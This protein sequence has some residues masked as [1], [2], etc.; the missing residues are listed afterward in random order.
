MLLSSVRWVSSR[1]AGL[2]SSA[3]RS[4]LG[5]ACGNDG[6]HRRCGPG[7]PGIGGSPTVVTRWRSGWRGR[8]RSPVCWAGCRCRGLA[9]A[10][11]LP[12]IRAPV[13]ARPG[14]CSRPHACAR[15]R[16][17]ARQIDRQ[18]SGRGRSRI[19]RRGCSYEA[20]RAPAPMRTRGGQSRSSGTA[21]RRTGPTRSPRR[22]GTRAPHAVGRTNA[23]VRRRD[24]RR[25]L[26]GGSSS[27]ALRR[28]GRGVDWVS[29]YRRVDAYAGDLRPSPRDAP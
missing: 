26:L 27:A 13:A 8:R 21:G 9:G 14:A 5:S 20:T 18:S 12:R 15:R 4:A 22:L 7:M 23:S 24:G 6:V 11:T 29:V 10:C 2:P 28:P 1:R 25:V 17:A 16:S 3:S 19:G